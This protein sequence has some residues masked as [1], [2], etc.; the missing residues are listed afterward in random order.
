MILAVWVCTMSLFHDIK[1]KRRKVDTHCNSDGEI[2]ADINT[3]SPESLTTD[4][5][6]KDLDN[7]S[8]SGAS[9]TQTYLSED[10]VSS[11]GSGSPPQLEIMCSDTHTNRN[12]RN[13]A[14]PPEATNKRK[15]CSPNGEHV[16]NG[17][18][19]SPQH[20]RRN[21]VFDG[22]GCRNGDPGGL[23]LSRTKRDAS[24]R[25]STSPSSLDEH[26]MSILRL[27]NASYKP[28]FVL[29]DI[30][31]TG[32]PK[33]MMW[34]PSGNER[35]YESTNSLSPDSAETMRQANATSPTKVT[36]ISVSNHACSPLSQPVTLVPVTA[37]G[38]PV[39][40]SSIYNTQNKSVLSRALTSYNNCING[41]GE[42]LMGY[43]PS[44]SRAPYNRRDG[45]PVGFTR[46]W[47]SNGVTNG[48]S[49]P[50]GTIVSSSPPVHLTDSQAL[51]LTVCN[52]IVR[53]T[54]IAIAPSSS[55]NHTGEEDDEDDQPMV[56]M[57]C[58][59]KATGLHYGIITCEG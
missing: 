40:H 13:T 43:V 10:G 41:R 47:P 9:T 30:S 22:G 24:E 28:S 56:C 18:V 52:S 16:M 14:S 12:D 36:P 58:E 39:F 57:I 44:S 34:S 7:G 49:K 54:E 1:L 59:D 3:S 8:A 11:L 19:E 26:S 48:E 46:Y 25:N 45:S 50:V 35:M 21:S 29:G 51:N 32:P 38:S 2:C 20:E 5:H 37:T 15:E 33:T 4:H 6:V 27:V 31:S 42:S 55:I 23:D 53:K 17:F